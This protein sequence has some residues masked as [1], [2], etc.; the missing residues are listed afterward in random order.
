M[1]TQLKGYIFKILGVIFIMR[2]FHRIY[3]S[4]KFDWRHY[5]KLYDLYCKTKHNYYSQSAG[6]L[7]SLT[8]LNSSSRVIDLACGTGALS[9]ELLRRC[10][11]INIFAIDLSKEMLF[12]YKK[13]FSKFIK[14]GQIKATSGNAEN[15]FRFVNSEFDAIFICSALWDLEIETTLKNSRKVLKKGGYIVF[16]LPALVAEKEKGFIFFI[17]HFFRQRMNTSIFYKRIK[18]NKLMNLFEKHGFELIKSKGYSFNMGKKNVEKFFNLLRYRYPFILFP[19]DMPYN[20]K[21]K[22]CTEIFQDSLR[23][24]PKEGINEEGIAFILRKK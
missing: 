11:S 6:I 9:K 24:I 2:I 15:V 21:L 5:S 16:N 17:E 8:G 22:R 18:L 14:K 3:W 1:V 23:Y 20:E 13:N 7:T 10:P 12:Y 4:K 19:E